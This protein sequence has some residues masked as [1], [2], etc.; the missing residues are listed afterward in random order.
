MSMHRTRYI[1]LA[2]ASLAVAA[3]CLPATAF[4]ATSPS[5]ADKTFV[6]ANEQVNLAEIAIGQLAMTHSSSAA[7]RT[8]AQK[9]MSDHMAA[10]AKLTT[11]AANLGL[12][13]PSAPNAMQQAQA[14]QLKGLTGSSFDQLYL[15]DQVAGHETSI[16]GTDTEIR[17]GSSATVVSYARGYLPVAQ[18]HLRM[19]QADLASSSGS[20][21]GSVQAGSG[22]QAATNEGT[23]LRL[24]WTAGAVGL[25]LLGGGAVYADRRRRA[26]R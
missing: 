1:T 24:G 19:A 21:P 7:V 4:A 16:A 17:T 11:V 6:T 8:L 23:D 26:L 5:T 9:T 13:L 20:G 15:R 22:G 3:T 18:M 14:A 2:G 12:P 10:K 25:A